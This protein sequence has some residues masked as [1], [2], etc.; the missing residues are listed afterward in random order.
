MKG[1]K[2]ITK[3]DRVSKEASDDYI[4][5]TVHKAQISDSGTYFV[6]ARN[7]H[8]TDRIFTTITVTFFIKKIKFQN[9]KFKFSFL[10]IK[11]L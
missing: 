10:L 7:E 4:R 9:F 6:I 1:T 2:D 11:I 5:F 8:G 3:S